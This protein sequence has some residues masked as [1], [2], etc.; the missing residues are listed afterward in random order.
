M[1]TN[2]FIDPSD[3]FKQILF[4]QVPRHNVRIGVEQTLSKKF[5]LGG[6]L[7]VGIEFLHYLHVE[8]LVVHLGQQTHN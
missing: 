7:F 4:Y 5:E 2:S 6:I 8:E 1:Q 3:P